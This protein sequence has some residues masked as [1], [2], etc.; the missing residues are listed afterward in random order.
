MDVVTLG[1]AL[2][3]SKKYTDQVA[4][5]LMGGVHY[6]GSVS[7]Y[8]DLP[9]DAAEGD[10][11][12][13]KYAGT[14]G[15][16]A[17]GTE[18]TWGYDTDS[19]TYAW[20]SFSKDAYSK[21]ETDALL[22]GKQN[23]ID[24]SHKLDGSLI[25]PLT[26]YTKS[27]T[28]GQAVSSSDS[29]N[30][31][32]GKIEKRVSDNETNILSKA[33]T[34]D[35]NTATA[36][37][38]AQINN[39]ITPVTQD[40]EVQTAR[41]G[42]DGTTYASL[43]SRLDAEN[44]ELTAHSLFEGNLYNK[45]TASEDGKYIANDG[46]VSNL[47][48]YCYSDYIHVLAGVKYTIS[49][50]FSSCGGFYDES[51]NYVGKP[52]TIGS[53]T[54]NYEYTPTV[55]GYVRLNVSVAEKNTFAIVRG[56]MPLNVIPY[57]E[58]RND[59]LKISENQIDG[60][61]DLQGNNVL[62]SIVGDFNKSYTSS[63][64]IVTT[65]KFPY[66]SEGK[67]VYG[68]GNKYTSYRYNLINGRSTEFKV[69]LDVKG[70]STALY[71]ICDDSDNVLEMYGQPEDMNVHEYTNYT[72]TVSNNNASYIVFSDYNDE[73]TTNIKYTS[74]AVMTTIYDNLQDASPE[75]SALIDKKI[76]FFGD[77]RTWYDGKPYSELAKAEWEG[78]I[79]SGYQQTVQKLT[80]ATIISQGVS[81]DT[82]KQICDRIRVYNFTNSDCV[83]LEG[84]VNDFVKSSQVTIG[85]LAPIGSTFNTNTIYGAWQSAIEYIMNN[86]P[87][88]KIFIDIPAI[89]WL[90]DQDEVF[91]YEVAKIKKD[92]ADLYNLPCLDLY[93]EGGITSVNRDYFYCDDVEKTNNWRLHFNDYGN[94]KI[95]E[96]IAGFILS[97]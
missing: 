21:A 61:S 79:C 5:S 3:G 29:L 19:Q 77:S 43:K 57:G 82:S 53:T 38:Q 78:S 8:A 87:S 2:N 97:H 27:Q 95:G 42:A 13:V 33:N 12:T 76:V 31:A 60:L 22:G 67:L 94:K 75:N 48:G 88:V 35:V 18:Y 30:T 65:R 44:N 52:Y 83:F 36:N 55:S 54:Y 63:G 10:S 34:S 23:V 20:I 17:D 46:T 90:G 74:F 71:Y 1:A 4:Q 66:Q 24:S 16:V 62:S 6:R 11:Y 73:N 80:R 70:R 47:A 96:I 15:S 49:R 81:G 32:L 37:L 7:Y 89:A 59:K 28:G 58:L 84:G 85:E 56:S 68:A 51:K 86:Y 72:F 45:S 39:I 50:T 9:N 93:K 14:S 41:V 25:S 64:V 69:S 40:A 92:V 26:D 91:P